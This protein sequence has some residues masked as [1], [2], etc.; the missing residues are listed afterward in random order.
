MN[1][2]ISCLLAAILQAAADD[3]A[4][5]SVEE[6]PPHDALAPEITWTLLGLFHF[7]DRSRCAWRTAQQRLPEAAG[8]TSPGVNLP[9]VVPG[10][11]EWTR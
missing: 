5:R 10:L 6:M 9:T 3:V 1:H 2:R 8:K 7:R 4:R 11:P